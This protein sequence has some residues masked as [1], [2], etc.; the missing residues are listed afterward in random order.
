MSDI[1]V[2]TPSMPER[3]DMRHEAMYCVALQTLRP[4]EHRIGIDYSER[5]P[6]HLLNDLMAGVNTDY[7]A[8]LPDDDL[9]HEGHL[10]KLRDAIEGHDM[11]YSE[12]KFF[13]SAEA[14]EKN[15]E[16]YWGPLD[17]NRF[18][19]KKD[20][21]LRGAHW[22]MRTDVFRQL[23]GLLVWHPVADWEFLCRFLERDPQV[24]RVDEYTWDYRLHDHSLSSR[25]AAGDLPDWA[26]A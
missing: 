4:A 23:G 13:G 15:E 1:T 20:T 2:V 7:F 14:I 16:L 18:I 6:Y 9:W 24:A 19:A 10:E 17:V 11:A 26:E 5:G 21:G 12:G 8:W 22:L 25:L 3:G